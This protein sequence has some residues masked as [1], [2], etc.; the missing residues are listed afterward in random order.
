MRKIK[1]LLRL[2]F[3]DLEQGSGGGRNADG[4][5]I[6]KEGAPGYLRGTF[7]A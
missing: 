5:N 2:K 3:P 6:S 1:D 7:S 4:G